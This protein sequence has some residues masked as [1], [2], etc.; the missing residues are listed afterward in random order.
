MPTFFSFLDRVQHLRARGLAAKPSHSDGRW[1][2]DHDTLYCI[3]ALIQLCRVLH[4]GRLLNTDVPSKVE[5][6]ES[7]KYASFTSM[8]PGAAEWIASCD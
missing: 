8:G 5:R 3:L 7:S 4:D 6:T 2:L 1:Y